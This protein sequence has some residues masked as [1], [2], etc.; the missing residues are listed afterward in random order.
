MCSSCLIKHSVHNKLSCVA[1]ATVTDK[2]Y[3]RSEAS[4][5]EAERALQRIRDMFQR[6]PRDKYPAPLTASHE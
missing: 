5:P 6:G 3:R 2:F 1:A 4:G